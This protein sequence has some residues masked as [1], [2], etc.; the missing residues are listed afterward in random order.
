[1]IKITNFFKSVIFFILIIP[2]FIIVLFYVI[3]VALVNT[4]SCIVDSY[5]K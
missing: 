4:K 3:L 2:L 5:K 1:M